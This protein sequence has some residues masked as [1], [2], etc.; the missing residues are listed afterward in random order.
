[1]HIFSKT[2]HCHKRRIPFRS[3]ADFESHAVR[4]VYCPSCE[5]EAP[6]EAVRVAVMAVPGWTGHYAIH[7]DHDSIT[8]TDATY[9]PTTRAVHALIE[10]G[11][12]SFGFLP[13]VQANRSFVVLGQK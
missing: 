11:K 2:C 13:R 7:L 1:M 10:K 4:A 6:D 12:L 8:H 5:K 9:R 3:A